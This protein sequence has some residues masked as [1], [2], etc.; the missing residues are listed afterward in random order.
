MCTVK[1]NHISPQCTLHHTE[2]LQCQSVGISWVW[3]PDQLFGIS[4]ACLTNKQEQCYSLV[5]KEGVHICFDI[6]FSVLIHNQGCILWWISRLPTSL[7]SN[8]LHW[9]IAALPPPTGLEVSILHHSAK[10]EMSFYRHVM[11]IKHNLY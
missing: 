10:L 3:Q 11:R 5:P 2:S 9:R 1:A 6:S 4:K 8:H 7:D